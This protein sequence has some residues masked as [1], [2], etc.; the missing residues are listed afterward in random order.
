MEYI[1]GTKE[2]CEAY[3]DKV[4]KGQNYKCTTLKFDEI[5]EINGDFY[6]TKHPDYSTNSK[7]VNELPK[8]VNNE[9]LI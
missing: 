6:I 4:T 8:I 2:E 9:Y 3:N 1:K 5:R 7:V